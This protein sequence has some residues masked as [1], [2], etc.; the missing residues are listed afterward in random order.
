MKSGLLYVRSCCIHA[1]FDDSCVADFVDEINFS[2]TNVN[3]VSK[4]GRVFTRIDAIVSTE[5]GYYQ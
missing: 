4:P 1:G 5:H 3:A 2:L